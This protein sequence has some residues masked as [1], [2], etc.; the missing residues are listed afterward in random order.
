VP[1]PPALRLS[2]EPWIPACESVEFPLK[3]RKGAGP[4]RRVPAANYLE[5]EGPVEHWKVSW[6]QS[7]RLAFTKA[8][9]GDSHSVLD[10]I[11]QRDNIALQT[12]RAGQ[13]R[14]A[15][16]RVCIDQLEGT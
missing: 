14:Q 2:P 5:A 13:L 3:I 16:S 15:G 12:D 4:N 11:L 7:S 1:K 10:V 9:S 6:L 8:E